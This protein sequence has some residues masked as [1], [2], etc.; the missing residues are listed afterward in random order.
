[1]RLKFSMESNDMKNGKELLLAALR[2]ESTSRSPWVPFVGVHGGALVGVDAT[3]YLQ[4]ADHIVNGLTQAV[5][6]YQPDG[7]PVVFDLQLEAEILGCDLVWAKETPPSVASHPLGEDYN[8]AGLPEFSLGAGRLPLVLDAVR[9][10]KTGFGEEVALYGLLTGPL[11]LALHLRGDDV[12][13]DMFDEEDVVPELL[14]Y[15]ADIAIKMVDAYLDAG[16]D[17]IAVVDPMISQI[18]PGHFSDFVTPPLNK[19]FDHVRSRGALS[20]LF[21]CGNATRNLEPM[22]ATT[23]DNISV[24]ENVDM[25][26]LARIARAG[27]KS[28][29]GNLQL[30]VVLL[31][32]QPDD[33]CRDAVR[34]LDQ[35]GEGGGFVLAPGCDL[36][37][38][39]NPANLEVIAGLVHDPAQLQLA[40]QLPAKDADDTFD[41]IEIPNYPQEQEVIVD[42]VTLDSAGCAPCAYMLKSAQEAGRVYGQPVA[43]REHKIT[44]RDGLGY[45][46][47]LGVSAIPSI[48]VDGQEKF[49]SIIP[50]R[51]ALVAEFSAA[52]TAKNN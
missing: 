3:T 36:P 9:R 49:A 5:K 7:L 52:A 37:Y 4:D 51:E 21:V 48:C 31:L 14:D 16:I 38:A 43:V 34:C 20:S 23:C 17:V 13:L 8:I 35:A 27:G 22:C 45:M 15:C 10:C 24:D 26:E 18:S 28:F 39:V 25:V 6:R 40:R 12:L 41:D 33:A 42:V 2:G 46:V 44:G 30:T 29:G 1:M 47:K 32:G 19:I 11:T 50:D